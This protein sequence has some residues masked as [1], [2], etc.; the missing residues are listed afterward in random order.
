MRNKLGVALLALAIV[1]AWRV[2]SREKAPIGAGTFLVYDNAGT[3]MRLTFSPADGGRFD[4]NVSYLDEDGTHSSAQAKPTPS[5]VVDSR[6]RTANGVV[7]E[8]GSLG[9]LW[10]PPSEVRE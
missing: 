8:L 9:P 3:Q 2:P 6:M 5:I 10:V 7:F 4:T 1:V